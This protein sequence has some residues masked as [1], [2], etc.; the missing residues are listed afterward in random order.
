[1]KKVFCLLLVTASLATDSS[2]QFYKSFLPSPEFTDALSKIVLDYRFNYRNIQG[3]SIMKEGG[4]ETY[5]SSIKVP[6]ASDCVISYF[7]SKIDTTASWQGV[8]YRGENFKDASKVYQNVYRLVRKSQVRWVDKTSF[9]FTGEMQAPKEETRFA[10]SR[11]KFDLEDSRY[12]TFE[13]E[14]ELINYY[15]NW[16]VH[17]NLQSRKRDD[18]KY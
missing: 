10:V 16:E 17:L 18:E 5:V 1:M 15:E 2:A 8:M 11:L 6:G 14:V 4:Y 9:G 12:R 3:D 13:A 7:N